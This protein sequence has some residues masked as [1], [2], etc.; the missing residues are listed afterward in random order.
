MTYFED[1]TA[2]KAAG[3]AWACVCG[4]ENPPTYDACHDCQRPSWTCAA[5]GLVSPAAL[6]ACRE[7]GNSTSAESLGDEPGYEMSHLAWAGLQIGPRRVGGHYDHGSEDTA[8]EVITIE[9]GPRDTWPSWQITV[10]YAM[11]GR[12]V[13]HCTGWDP[14]RDRVITQ[15][16]AD[17]IIVSIGRLHDFER[18]EHAD[19]LQRAT[20]ALDL[21]HHFRD[22][23]RA[24]DL[25]DLSA[26][27]QAVRQAVI[28][29]PGVR[30]VLA[31]TALQISGYLSGPSTAPITVVTQCA[32]GR[33]RAATAALALRAV[34]A[35]DV[36]Q[37]TEFGLEG[38]SRAFSFRGL[39][40]E[41]IHRDINRAV[42]QR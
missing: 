17:I 3:S 18:S 24:Q 32:G 31:A 28:N 26:A 29:T 11:D 22:P 34:V 27:D 39:D 4:A 33:H 13:T 36:E 20:I 14:S 2:A 16:P 1:L 7:C 25:R 10:R 15:P 40:V 37:A 42:V 21:R 8:Y 19:I 38:A 23:H 5:C 41:L 30:Q 6:Q 9:H 12:T 35:G